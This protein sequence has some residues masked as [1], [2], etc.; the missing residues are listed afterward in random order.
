MFQGPLRKVPRENAKHQVRVEAIAMNPEPCLT[1]Q[2]KP[3][4]RITVGSRQ[5]T[6]RETRIA[7]HF[8]APC[9]PRARLRVDSTLI[10]SCWAERR[11]TTYGLAS[12]APGR[13]D[14][15]RSSIWTL[16]SIRSSRLTSP[17]KMRQKATV[18]LPVINTGVDLTKSTAAPGAIYVTTVYPNNRK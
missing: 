14:G 15:A 4:D 1:P 3:S 10:V 13:T 17:P 6:P 16:C 9:H 7:E 12:E 18:P 5:R 2:D 8:S 11:P